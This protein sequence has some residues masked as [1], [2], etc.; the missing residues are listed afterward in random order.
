MTT[1]L[2]I[3]GTVVGVWF[4]GFLFITAAIGKAFF[5]D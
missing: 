1:F 5:D 4:L 3:G 2:V